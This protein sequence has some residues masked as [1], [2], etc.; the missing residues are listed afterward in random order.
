VSSSTIGAQLIGNHVLNAVGQT[1]DLLTMDQTTLN[2]DNFIPG[3]G[4]PFAM[5]A[6]QLLSIGGSETFF[7]E[8]LELG[9]NLLINLEEKGQMVGINA[10]YSLIE[11]LSIDGSVR[12][13]KGDDKPENR[14]EQ[15]EDFSHFQFQ[16]AYSF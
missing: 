6:E 8:S 2:T 1:F 10:A 15:L 12:Y 9:Y 5:I 13:F 16:L 4:T 3:L 14:F 7:D 11:N